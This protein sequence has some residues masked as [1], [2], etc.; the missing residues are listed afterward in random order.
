MKRSFN[1]HNEL[2]TKYP[3][4]ST[5]DIESLSDFIKAKVITNLDIAHLDPSE[6][7]LISIDTGMMPKVK[8]ENRMRETAGAIK[9]AFE[10]N[11]TSSP[12][13]ITTHKSP[14]MDSPTIFKLERGKSYVVFVSTGMMPY[15]K[16]L[17]YLHELRDLS[18]TF[19][20]NGCKLYFH[21]YND[22][23][24]YS[25]KELEDMHGQ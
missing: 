14:S 16:S 17:K 18:N 23:S 6:T 1:Y 2:A 11:G 19:E 7:Y 12:T 22:E 9:E 5:E 21:R 15:E 4:L 3:H 20:M 10:L 25:I 8:A 24:I 13:I